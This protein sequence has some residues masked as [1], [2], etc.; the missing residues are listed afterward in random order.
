MTFFQ[1]EKIQARNKQK[2]YEYR[3]YHRAKRTARNTSLMIPPESRDQYFTSVAHCR[4][5]CQVLSERIE[6]DSIKTTP[7]NEE[8]DKF[9]ADTLE[10]NGGADFVNQAHM[11]AMEYGRAYLVPTGSYRKDGLPVIQLITAPHMVHRTDP[12]SGEVVEAL[13][14]WGPRGDKR[15][16]YTPG[17]TVYFAASGL[18]WVM[19]PEVPQNPVP[20]PDNKIAVYPLICRGEADTTFGRPEAKD[21]YSLQDSGCRIATDMSYASGTMAAPQRIMHGIEDE[22]FTQRNPDGTTQTDPETG[23]AV[24]QT[25]AQ[26]Y[27]ARLLTMSDPLSKISEFTAAQL[28]NFATAANANTRQTAAIL[29]VPQSVFGVASDANPA[30]G[31]GQRQDDARLVRRAEQLTRGF[32]PAWKGVY[33]DLLRRNGYGDLKVLLRW[34]NPA[35]PNLAALADSVLK[36]ATVRVAE[37]GKEIPLY[38]WEELRRMLGDSQPDIDK[39]KAQLENQAIISLLTPAPAPPASP[40]VAA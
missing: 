10:A 13:R 19:D 6:L 39:A 4:L 23:E 2:C 22:D 16:Y 21:A 1:L 33:E 34:M 8:A 17:R 38:T 15:A 18:G 31:D 14:V 20:N 12:Y 11:S 26:I 25:G 32:Q 35:L 29:G 5:A 40:P 7:E 36:L 28:Q 27:T 24:K 30:S 3:I 9:L 37:G